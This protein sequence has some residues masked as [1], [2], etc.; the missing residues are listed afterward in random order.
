MRCTVPPGHLQ[1]S[2]PCS[3]PDPFLS[4]SGG[5]TTNTAL[6]LLPNIP[7]RLQEPF[8]ILSVRCSISLAQLRVF[9][10]F[11][12]SDIKTA[13]FKYSSATFVANQLA[14]GKDRRVVG[15]KSVTIC[16]CLLVLWGILNRYLQVKAACI[17]QRFPGETN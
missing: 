5:G 4:L 14:F 11:S 9:Y 12:P 16:G 15:K 1:K 6:L 7:P 3:L 2:K 10:T 17:L 13:P 8:L